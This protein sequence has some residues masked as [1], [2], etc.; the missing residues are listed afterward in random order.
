MD[1]LRG[2]ILQTAHGLLQPKVW[3]AGKMAS[4]HGLCKETNYRMSTDNI[5]F[6][7]VGSYLNKTAKLQ[8]RE[9]EQFCHC[10]SGFWIC[11]EQFWVLQ[12]WPH[13]LY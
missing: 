6:R 7:S 1:R 5:F 11:F 2:S 12:D 4:E 10:D 8:R 9:L 3:L 13:H